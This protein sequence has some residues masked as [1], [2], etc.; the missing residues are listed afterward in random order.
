MTE[1]DYEIKQEKN[2]LKRLRNEVK[3]Y[4]SSVKSKR[5]IPAKK[6]KEPC[7]EKCRLNALRYKI[8]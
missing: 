5:V 4:I 2:T 6:L 1:R 3:E 7:Y 8:Y